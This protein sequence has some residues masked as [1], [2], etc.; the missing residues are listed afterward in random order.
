MC[1]AYSELLRAYNKALS[2]FNLA[3]AAVAAARATVQRR[4]YDRLMRYVELAHVEM[5]KAKGQVDEHTAEH[6]CL[7]VVGLV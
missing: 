3:Q 5:D 1:E 6:G 2:Q 4:E 7:A